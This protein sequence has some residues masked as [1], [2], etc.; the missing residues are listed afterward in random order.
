MNLLA[1]WALWLSAVGAAI[2]GLYILKIKRRA[3]P[4]PALDFWR[5][6]A[7]PA[8]VRSLFHRLKRWWS[9]LLWLVIAA[10]LMLAVGNPVLSLGPLKPQ[11]IAVILDN[12]ASMQAAEPG[13]DG[14]SRL[15][16]AQAALAGIIRQRPVNDEW[17]LIEAGREPRVVQAWTRKGG[18]IVKAAAV[19]DPYAGACDLAAARELAGQLLEGKERPCVLIIS[20][21][22]A[23]QVEPL[24]VDET[25]AY[26]P[27]GEADDNLGITHLRVRPHR[28]QVSHHAYV[29]VVNASAHDLE[30]RVVFDI[31]GSTAA[32]EPLSVPAGGDWEKT[33]VL[34]APEGGV[35]RARID[36]SDVLALDNE[37]SA[38]LDP[39]RPARILLVTASQD[40]FF[41]EQALLAMDPLVDA[42]SSNTLSIEHYDMQPP[43][44]P[45][46]L[47]IFDNCA[48]AVLPPT[49][50][51]VFVNNWPREIP[52]RIVG[53]IEAPQMSVTL[54]DH[55]LTGHLNLR[56]VKL[57]KALQVDLT[58]RAMVLAR[59]ADGAP[60]IFLCEQPDRAALCVAFD[61][62]DSD[63]PFRNAFPL[64]LR[65]AVTYLV[66]QGASW[67]R[68][69]YRIGEVIE[70]L[71][72][73]P[74]TLSEVA[75]SRLRAGE[76][77]S[78]MLPV[79]RGGF[80]FDTGGEPVALRFDIGGEPAFTAVNLADAGES[81]LRPVPPP[82]GSDERLALSKPL[83]GTAP[84]LALAALATVLVGLEWL[85]YHR[86][87]TE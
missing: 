32:V 62:L 45:P 63:L 14:R 5:R 41:F 3:E 67:V 49:G 4:V 13:F 18:A 50:R 36:R 70:P 78:E 55:A 48:P 35:L 26:R 81:R 42:S 73:L 68:D 7:G 39:I 65:N 16:L 12:S 29:R 44:A 37:A 74:A 28:Q 20:D 77:G 59:S 60:L 51:Y 58:Q 86:R 21:G 24:L 25:V 17:M 2:V 19:I 83:L 85:T 79:R 46:D 40:S 10:C 34:E 64:L 61:V 54:R 69:Q 80:L 31:D 38:I 56:P 6:L 82:A 8:P 72:P 11:S 47:T 87:W 75:V 22:A 30:S 57:V 66:M 33:V 1:P 53:T 43:A 27:V 23:G 76:V 52:A 71:R 15:E 84:W 9:M